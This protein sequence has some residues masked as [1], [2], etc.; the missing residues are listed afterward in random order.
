MSAPEDAGPLA[1]LRWVDAGLDGHLE[2][3]D[4]R[5]LPSERIA[6]AIADV[7]ELRAAIVDLAV[8]GAPAI[9]IAAAY[10][11]AQHCCRLARESDPPAGGE[12]LEDGFAHARERLLESRPTAVNLAWALDRC[13]D[14]F[15][16]HVDDLTAR[17]LA[18][19]LLM[20]AKRIHAEDARCCEAI[21]ANG[22]PLMPTEGGIATICNTGALA[23]GGI[24]TA[25]GCIRRAF[26]DGG[27]STVFPC[28]TRPLLQGA[29]L[30]A[31]ELAA[32]GIPSRLCCDSA[33]A[34]LMARGAIDAVIVGADRIAANGDTANK[35]GTYALAIASHH[36][37][38]PFYVAAPYSTFDLE[39]PNGAAIPIEERDGD[40]VRRSAGTAFAPPDFPAANP[41]FDVTPAALITAI[42]TERGVIDGP[43]RASVARLMAGDAGIPAV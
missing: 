31:A 9:G 21:A 20:E 27:R 41:A 14:C 5:R 19:R 6:L 16:R 36:H 11:L 1:A 26:E 39:I 38:I 7:E 37:R 15:D 24:G 32:L 17:E 8:R 29:R 10:G 35:V 2:L 23:T 28:E 22:A 30:T 4:Q 13:R 3:C 34:S 43:D 42:V 25:F 12:V 18:A 33:V 40:E